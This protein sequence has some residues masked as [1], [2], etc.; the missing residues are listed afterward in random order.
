MTMSNSTDSL[1]S[2]IFLT[3]LAMRIADIDRDISS[4]ERGSDRTERAKALRLYSRNCQACAVGGEARGP[5][6]TRKVSPRSAENQRDMI[7]KALRLAEHA[8]R[9]DRTVVSYTSVS[10]LR[11]LVRNIEIL[12][13]GRSQPATNL[14]GVGIG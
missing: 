11:Q 12:S 1:F 7:R 6:G 2:A 4:W 8:H 10:N 13:T 5:H 9:L 3:V 14:R